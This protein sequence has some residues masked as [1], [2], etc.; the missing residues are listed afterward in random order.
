MGRS[1]F[2]WLSWWT[3]LALI[4]QAGMKTSGYAA[5]SL[6]TVADLPVTEVAA[7][8][9]ATDRFGGMS[10]SDR[11]RILAG[12]GVGPLFCVF[13]RPTR[14]WFWLVAQHSCCVYTL[15]PP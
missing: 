2:C 6:L 9:A 14:K 13:N 4:E 15:S 5:G 3:E 8:L 1:R 11:A 10:G 7:I 12:R